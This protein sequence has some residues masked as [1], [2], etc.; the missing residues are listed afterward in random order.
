MQ[1]G[2]LWQ[3]LAHGQQQV[4]GRRQR[5]AFGYYEFGAQEGL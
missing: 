5:V 2:G 4:G 3:C 1:A